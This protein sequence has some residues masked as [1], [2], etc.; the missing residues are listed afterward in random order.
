MRL[1]TVVCAIGVAALVGGLGRASAAAA[2]SLLDGRWSGT[3]RAIAVAPGGTA[4]GALVQAGGRVTGTLAIELGPV[5]DTFDVKGRVEGRRAL[6]VGR[7]G[8]RRLRWRGRWSARANGWRGPLVV[9]FGAMRL[10]ATLV[11]TRTADG[12]GPRC[13]AELFASTVMPVV[14]EP[15]CSKCHVAGGAAQAAAFRVTLGDPVATAASALA[16]VDPA[17]PAASRLL[18]KPRGDVPHGGGRQIAAGSPEEQALLAWIAEVT[19][20]GCDLGG[21]GGGG[22]ATGGAALYAEACASCHG[23][24]ARGLDG[25]P[26][27]RCNRSIHDAV[28]NGRTGG[29]A[30]DMPSFPKLDDAQIAEIQSFLFGLCPVGGASGADLYASNCATCHGPGAVGTATA[31]NVRCATRVDDALVVGRGARM[32]SFSALSAPERALLVGYLAGACAD[33]GRP[34][35]DLYSGN[36]ASCHGARGGGGTN[37]L[38]VYGPNIRCTEVG[39]Y[40]EKIRFGEGAMPAFPGLTPSDATA[41]AAFARIA[42]CTGD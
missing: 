6:V 24:D 13:G 11:L 12:G 7:H 19:A 23:A 25:R 37:G 18:A 14:V 38:G 39:D 34:A 22:G 30:G 27:I 17:D 16:M 36:C 5:T 10:R 21:G 33:A 9:R 28:R 4:S 8:V 32:P 31:P 1:Q 29:P 20:P 42:G 15:I 41:I 35:A 26:D 3:V 40:R 2:T